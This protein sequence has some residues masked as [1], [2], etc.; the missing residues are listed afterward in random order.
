EYEQEKTW[1]KPVRPV[2][3]KLGGQLNQLRKIEEF[4]GKPNNM[5]LLH[6]DGKMPAKRV[7][8]VG[9]GPR[10][11]VTLERIRQAMGTAVKRAQNINA[12]RMVCVMPEPFK[13]IGRLNDIAQA[14]IEGVI[15]GEYRFTQYRTDRSDHKKAVQSCTLLA[16]SS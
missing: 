16:P 1:S 2:D 3:Q 12:K 8:L 15:L 13:A 14:M 7:L 11:T 9:M 5:A 6:I 4:S 10:E